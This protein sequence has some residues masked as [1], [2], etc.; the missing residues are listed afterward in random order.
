MRKLSTKM[1]NNHPELGSMLQMISAKKEVLKNLKKQQNALQ[2]EIKSDEKTLKK[3]VKA[4]SKGKQ[5]ATKAPADKPTKTS[6]KAIAIQ[7]DAETPTVRRAGRKAPV[8]KAAATKK[9]VEKK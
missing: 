1:L 7:Q 2:S 4:L 6:G 5:K 8:K 3:H 9:P